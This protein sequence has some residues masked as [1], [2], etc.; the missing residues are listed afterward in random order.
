MPS[1]RRTF[2]A[3]AAAAPAVSLAARGAEPSA[4]DETLPPPRYQLAMNLE[5]MFPRG[6]SYQDRIVE[7][8]DVR[9]LLCARLVGRHQCRR[10]RLDVGSSARRVEPAA[11]RSSTTYD[12]PPGHLCSE[13]GTASLRLRAQRSAAEKSLPGRAVPSWV[14]AA[15]PRQVR[16]K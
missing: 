9:V 10:A 7:A 4:S 5:L 8:E 14:R 12:G 3:A 1:T 2:L 11:V 16:E 13:T 6:M 15:R